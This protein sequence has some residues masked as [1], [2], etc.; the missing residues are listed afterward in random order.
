MKI[1]NLGEY[2]DAVESIYADWNTGR[3][4]IQPWFRGQRRVSWDLTP[5]LYRGLIDSSLERELLRDF[6]LRSV[7]LLSS[8]PRNDLEWM[9]IMQ[10]YGLPTRLLDWSES[11]L[12]ALYFAVRDF[13]DR[14]DA[15]VWVLHPWSLNEHAIG[16]ISVPTSDVDDLSR[17][18][19][20]SPTKK[21]ERVISARIPVALRPSHS[22]PRIQAQQ[23]VFTLHGSRKAGLNI[24]SEKLEAVNLIVLT[25]DGG[26]KKSI[27]VDLHRA[28]VTEARFFPDLQGLC[29]EIAFRYS[30]S[31][32]RGVRR[33]VRQ[34]RSSGPLVPDHPRSPG[35]W[36][37]SDPPPRSGRR[38]QTSI[39]KT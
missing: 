7:P 13:Q 24:Q 38:R 30:K 17:Y 20:P 12:C 6:K 10:H 23:G 28:G 26:K 14:S 36:I 21:I 15:C 2:L 37:R 11:H 31:Y 5:G 32:M 9:F 25:I 3:S 19:L 22:T 16:M 35:S 8:A 39:M 34:P 27:L 1:R 18:C 4:T 29:A 33:R